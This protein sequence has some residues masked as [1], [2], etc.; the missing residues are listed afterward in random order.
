M[1]NIFFAFFFATLTLTV[2]G[3]A[4]AADETKIVGSSTVSKF[5]YV[6]QRKLKRQGISVTI[7]PTGTSGGFSLFC[8]SD[9][10]K[11]APVTLASRRI[12]ERE[13]A[14]CDAN[15]MHEILEF[16]LGLSGVVVAQKNT[17]RPLKL[18]RKDLFLALAA[19]TPVSETD[20]RLI[21]NPRKRWKDVRS[22]LPNWPIEIYGPPLTSGTRASFVDLAIEE[23]AREIDCIQTLRTN[24]RA[25]YKQVVNKIRTDGVWIDAGENDAVIIA[26][27]K[28]MP[29]ILGVVGYPLY[30]AH[31][32]KLSS[33]TIDGVTADPATIA[34]GSYPLSRTLR[35]YAKAVALAQ[36][37]DAL[38]FVEE[39][40]GEHAI[41]P[42][43]YLEREGLIPF[44]VK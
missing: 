1:R 40:T 15:G 19:I 4:R 41:G 36:N 32:D 17:K 20:C 11:F 37:S 42:D 13:I 33:A 22:D 28:S 8:S 14:L 24:N 9:N 5:A 39:I 7:E 6:S 35:V 29:R 43:G 31:D 3:S 26:A 10:P 30:K 21:P 27:I 25:S 16:D 23:G 44:G 18:T 34:D 2:N 38:S 12:K